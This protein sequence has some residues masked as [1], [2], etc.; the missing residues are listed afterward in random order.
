MGE[1][2]RDCTPEWLELLKIDKLKIDNLKI[3][4]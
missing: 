2:L 3:D 4:Q 1:Q